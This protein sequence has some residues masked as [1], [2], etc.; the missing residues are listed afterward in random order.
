MFLLS[1]DRPGN[2]LEEWDSGWK[3][4][5]EYLASISSKLPER[6][7]AYASADWHYNHLDPRA[8]HDAWLQKLEANE[9]SARVRDGSALPGLTMTLLG[10]Y[11]DRLLRLEHVGVL[12][13]SIGRSSAD[14]GDWQYDEVRLSACGN[15][16]HEIEFE[17]GSVLVVCKDLQYGWSELGGR[18]ARS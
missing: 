10:A 6:A 4:Y 18:H 14:F 13:Y 16:L 9:A 7:L 5:R 12:S 15:V 8:P 17:H 3:R 1:R 11:H 2:S